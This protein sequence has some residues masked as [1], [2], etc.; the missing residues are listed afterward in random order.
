MSTLDIRCPS[1]HV[2]EVFLNRPEVRNAFNDGVIAEL[3]EAF[4]ALGADP[5][6]RVVAPVAGWIVAVF[7]HGLWN[8]SAASGLAGFLS[9]YVVLQMPVFVL[10]DLDMGMNQWMSKPFE[11]P[12]TPMQRGKVLWEQDLEE[13]KGN[14]GR[15]LDKDGDAI[16]YRT[17]PGNRHPM[18]SWFARGTGHG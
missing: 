13:I 5:A 14:W 17:V 9:T 6:L 12:D 4:S 10:S 7:L 15:Y 16:P 11:Y 8:S 2:A 1:P 18:S 3:T